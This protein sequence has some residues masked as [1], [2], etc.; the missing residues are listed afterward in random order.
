MERII[1]L[2]LLACMAAAMA[3]CDTP[4]APPKT[5]G[6]G[7]LDT[8]M[9]NQYDPMES[10]LAT[11]LEAVRVNYRYRLEVLEAYYTDIGYADNMLAARRE[12]ANLDTA[13]VFKWY[14]LPEVTK[15]EGE[16]L[17]D[18]DQRMLVEYVV[19]ARQEFY[20]AAAALQEFYANRGDTYRAKVMGNLLKRFD[21]VRMYVYYPD[22]E[23]P[24]PELRPTA[25][26]P[27]ADA[28]FAE[29]Y[30]LFRD[31]KGLLH[32]FVTTSYEKERQAIQLFRK[33]I[34]D[35]PTST[36]IAL[37]AYY[38]GDIYKEYFDEDVLAVR[39]YERA[40]QW[41]PN[42]TEPARFQAATVHD[43]RLH[44]P[45][46]AIELYRAAIEMETNRSN[47][48]FAERRIPELEER[49]AN[50][51]EQAAALR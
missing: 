50:N 18:A 26:L 21:P 23:I 6:G 1:S 12:M 43:I 46:K 40:W 16:S 22:A 19:G 17:P 45:I 10:E 8:L 13:Q 14:G 35:Y 31:G 34:R 36:K 41:D 11:R 30:K 33:L 7:H 38:I 39:W 27:E 32:T 5:V 49:L 2:G 9:V 37:S 44:N 51:P 20:D 3:G 4:P 25:V 48:R 15:P 47:T 29:A 28:L 42:I 24:G